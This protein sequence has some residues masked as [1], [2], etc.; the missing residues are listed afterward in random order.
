[1]FLNIQEN[2]VFVA[3]SHY[4]LKN[5]QFLYFLQKLENEDIKTNQVILMGDNF[6]FLSGESKYFIK[7][8]KTAIELLNKL[9]FNIEMVYLEGNHDYNL[10][11]IFPN[12]KVIKREEQPLF[13]KYKDKTIALSHGDNFIN[14]Q[15]DLYC[16]IIRNSSLLK[17]LN[18]IDFNNFISKKIESTLL[19]KEI[20]HKMQDFKKLVGK[21]IDNYKTDIIIEGH[22]HQ[23]STYELGNKKYINIP[24]LCC[25]KKY[26]R[27]NNYE[28]IG[29]NIWVHF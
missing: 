27:L 22:Y 11:K 26:I 1:M 9:S 15:Y 10:Q 17:F 5:Q 3:D 20:C 6:D 23:G 14:W 18:M 12:I 13:A 28:F 16:S 24:S 25:D 4:N 29:E 2:A 8:N 21:R 19:E 7:K